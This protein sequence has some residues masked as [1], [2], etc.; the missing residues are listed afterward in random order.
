MRKRYLSLL[1]AIA[2]ILSAAPAVLGM[3]NLSIGPQPLVDTDAGWQARCVDGETDAYPGAVQQN[4]PCPGA[5]ISDP[6]D[7]YARADE[8]ID[9]ILN[10]KPLER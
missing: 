4:C 3:E 9:D 10:P 2:F 1:L 6:H 7:A 8:I 5:A